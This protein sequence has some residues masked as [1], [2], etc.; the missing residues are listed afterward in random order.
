MHKFSVIA[1]VWNTA[2]YLDP[3]FTSL[4][5]QTIAVG[6]RLEIVV[7]NDGSTDDSLAVCEAWRARH[8]DLVV[9]LQQEH[10]GPGAARDLGLAAATGEWVVFVDS[11]DFVAPDFLAEIDRVIAA[12]TA[13]RLVTSAIRR[14]HE[15]KRAVVDD[16]PLRARYAR[17]TQPVHVDGLGAT[18]LAEVAGLAIHRPTLE[19]LGVRFD[20]RLGAHAE[21]G[22]FVNAV[23]QALP[24]RTRIGHAPA[25]LYLQRRRE[26][27][28]APVDTAAFRTTLTL[29]VIPLL[30]RARASGRAARWL[31]CWALFVLLEQ[32]RYFVNRIERAPPA[33]DAEGR[34]Y[35][36]EFKRCVRLIERRAVEAFHVPGLSQ[37]Y[38][39]G[40]LNLIGLGSM[41]HH[42]V[43]IDALDEAKSLVRARYYGAHPRLAERFRADGATVV[44]L[45]PTVRAHVFL[46]ETFVFERIVWLP[47][48]PGGRLGAEIG[49]RPTRLSVGGQLG[50]TDE[51][52][53]DQIVAVL[54]A[55]RMAAAAE[56]IPDDELRELAT[57]PAV[58]ARYAGCWLLC[59]RDIAA[60][61]NAEHLYRHLQAA[62]PE[63]HAVFALNRDSVDWPRL[64]AD[65]FELVDYGS[66]EYQAVL[67][68]AAFLVSSHTL[69][70][71]LKSVDISR[72]ADIVR[73]KVVFLQHGV[74][75]DD[76]SSGLSRQNM[77]LFVTSTG[78]E[79]RS[80]VDG[81]TYRFSDKEVVLT[82]LPRH[83]RLL[84]RSGE[85]ERMILVMPTWRGELAGA[86]TGRGSERAIN[87]DFHRSRFAVEWRD[88]LVSDD[89]RR[90]L[91]R[92]GYRLVFCPH[93]NV[94]PYLPGFDLPPHVLTAS[95]SDGSL[96]ELFA[97]AAVMITD[98]SSVMFEMAMLRRPVIYYQFDE[99]TF[100]AGGH[101]YAKGYFDY[102]RDGFGP[103]VT[104]APALVAALGEVVA[105]AG[106]D[107]RYRE[108]AERTFTFADGRNC[109]RVTRA[110]LALNEPEVP[111]A[112]RL[113]GELDHAR[114]LSALERWAEARVAW[115]RLAAHPAHQQEAL[116]LG[117][118][119]ATALG[120][121]AAA[122]VALDKL[123]AAGGDAAEVVLGRARIAEVLGEAAEAERLYA[124]ARKDA[125]TAWIVRAAAV[126]QARILR[127]QHRRAAAGQVLATLPASAHADVAHERA[128]LAM[129]LNDW[130]GAV[131]ELERV[132]DRLPSTALLQLTRGYR[133]SGQLADARQALERVTDPALAAER[134]IEEAQLASAGGDW[135]L[136]DAL[137][138][139]IL[140][141]GHA[142]DMAALRL[143][144][145]KRML[146]DL[147][148][149]SALLDAAGRSAQ[150]NA[151]QL[152]RALL[153]TAMAS[154]TDAADAW[155]GVLERTGGK[156]REHHLALAEVLLELDD[157]TAAAT[158]VALFRGAG[159]D[160][161]RS[162]VLLKRLA[163]MGCDA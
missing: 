155:R 104:N 127:L 103:V 133:R 99:E 150:R 64:A 115:E 5:E 145:A 156:V 111:A 74:I 13:P 28:E 89:L 102:R 91:E 19:A 63:I 48:V 3:F 22:Q 154:W 61:D 21:G 79:Y 14:Y 142:P 40:L 23:L 41:P 78:P 34:T 124:A 128:V 81:G 11:D 1:P 66:A 141:D 118:A 148:G 55:R 29:G 7:I 157:L 131:A 134:R 24:P 58:V 67:I 32:L 135:P 88:F 101:T 95:Q 96:Q 77:D 119:A 87:P 18:I 160:S 153:L 152:E 49:N 4:I 121:T 20:P 54:R 132:R 139:E 162:D 123:A 137:W 129:D 51:I 130:R 31:Q 94:V 120:D 52:A 126:G 90:L 85:V 151:F 116:S 98:Y 16:H 35:S 117:A 149:A 80:I 8:P 56:A 86:L 15:A 100:F 6:E 45:H 83:D 140:D 75:K 27:G 113:R 42:K 147:A 159:P 110:I 72:Y 36:D 93:P 161:G 33:P 68:N 114:R 71:M 158:H 57:D 97:R 84:A 143:V 107:P 76:L 108:R 38:R 82:G 47:L 37:F 105:G 25:A 73:H 9:V 138:T 136:A 30:E 17:L 112:S 146:G 125:A 92:T 109:E 59:D 65:G 62:H 2:P 53:C 106:P 60:D 122:A 43:F 39:A 46:G 70:Y 144:R 10:A 26:N 163:R 12:Q 44:P 50:E 69:G